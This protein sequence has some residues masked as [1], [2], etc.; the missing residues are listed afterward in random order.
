MQKEK[1]VPA[2]RFKGFDEEWEVNRLSSY[3]S[4]V[5]RRNEQLSYSQNEVLSVS[6]DSG[7]INQI[8]YLGRSYAGSDLR[9]YKILE[10]SHI[11][12]TKSPLSETPFGIIKANSYEQGIVSTLYATYE[13]SSV[14]HPNFIE[15]YFSKYDRLNNYLH[16]LVNKGAKNTLLISDEAA[17]GGYVVFPSFDEQ[18]KISDLLDNLAMLIQSQELKLKKLNEVKQS[19]LNKIF[20]LY[21]QKVPEIRFSGYNTEWNLKTLEQIAEITFGQSPLS[22]YYTDKKTDHILVQGNADV[23]NRWVYPRIYTSQITKRAF[24]GDIIFSVRAPV[25]SVARSNYDIVIGRGVAAI[26][27]DDFIYFNLLW[28]EISQFWKSKSSGST[29]DSIASSELDKSEISVPSD[30]SEQQKIGAFFSSL[31]SLIRSQ[32][33]KLEKLNNIKQALLEKMFC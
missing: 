5:V 17:L 14:C 19:L 26:K 16:L 8:K 33:Q 31:D 24:I 7:V 25:G 10:L 12:Y 1:L 18:K 6:K 29:F 20:A 15:H 4:V 32:E 22:I 21:D 3:L 13:P 9:N 11:V 23:K 28:K 30:L 27:G 2:I